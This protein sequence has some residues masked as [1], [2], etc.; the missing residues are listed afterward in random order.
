MTATAAYA[1]WAPASV[2]PWSLGSWPGSAG[3]RSPTER[4]KAEPASR[5]GCA[6]LHWP[7]LPPRQ[8][9]HAPGL[10]SH[11]GKD[12]MLT[13]GLMDAGAWGRW[14]GGNRGQW[15]A[16]Q[17]HREAGSAFGRSV[18]E[19]GP[20]EPG[21]EPSDQGQTDAG[22]HPAYAAV[23]VI[24]RRALEDDAAVV[25]GQTGTAIA[26]LDHGVAAIGAAGQGAPGC[27]H[28]PGGPQHFG[29]VHLVQVDAE[30]VGAEPGQ[31]QQ[32]GHQPL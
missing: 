1:G 27:P 21:R 16:A 26:D 20:A 24:Q 9:P 10:P 32:V 28:R 17:P 29:Q 2:W 12:L 22:A 15:S 7:R 30:V 6:A 23:A 14:R 13:A 18:G 25:F 4:P 31:I 8:R 5:C 19:R 11:R 3:P